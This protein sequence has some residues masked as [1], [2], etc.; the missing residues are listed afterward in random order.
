MYQ[1]VPFPVALPT[2]MQ[3]TIVAV[4]QRLG[5]NEDL[6]ALVFGESCLNDA[7]GIVLYRTM[8]MFLH[9]R[10]SAGSI[11]MA[12]FSFVGVFLGSVLIGQC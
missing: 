1:P 4:L 11:F 5:A 7:V 3:V 2:C 9:R 10:V 8:S 6:F 12:L